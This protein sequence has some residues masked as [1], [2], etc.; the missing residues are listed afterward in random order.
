MSTPADAFA[1][2]APL[3]E[4]VALAK[5]VLFD[6]LAPAVR[7]HVEGVYVYGSFVA[8]ER[9]LDRD[10]EVSDLDVYVTVDD[11]ILPGAGDDPRE[12]STRFGATEH[13]LLCRLATQGA[14]DVFGRREA[15]DVGLPDA[16]DPVVATVERAERA[17]FHA[18]EMDI[19]LLRFRPLD[20]TLGTPEAFRSFVGGDPH[21]QVWP[22][23][24]GRGA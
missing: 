22:L 5:I 11:A 1:A 7:D 10:G 24:G 14:L 12:V 19:D 13:G 16:P 8:P 15:F 9:E 18:R 17:V 2:K 21:L 20:L 3:L 6:L 4:D 23:D